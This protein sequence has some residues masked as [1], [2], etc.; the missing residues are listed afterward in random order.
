METILRA[1]LSPAAAT[2]ANEADAIEALA[3]A[4]FQA[5]DR[6]GGDELLAQVRAKRTAVFV[7]EGIEL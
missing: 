3:Q 5:G 7:M 2:L 4:K 6:A 1:D